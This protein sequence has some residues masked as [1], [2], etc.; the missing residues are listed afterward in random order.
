MKNLSL[1]V[2]TLALLILGSCKSDNSG[3]EDLLK[4]VPSSA[5]AVVGIDLQEIIKDAGCSLK[6]NEIVPGKDMEQL[7]AKMSSTGKK[8]LMLLFNGNTG[9]A[10]EAAVIFYD[11][12]RLFLTFNL[13]DSAKFKSFSESQSGEKFYE[14]NGIQLLN[15]KIALKGDQVWVCL[16]DNRRIDPDGIANYASLSESRSFLSTD[17]AKIILEKEDDIVGWGDFSALVSNLSNRS[18]STMVSLAAGL[19]FEDVEAVSFSW[20]F[21]KG[22]ADFELKFLNSKGK[23]AKYLLPADKININTVKKLGGSCDVLAALTLSPKTFEKFEKLGSAFGGQLFGNMKDAFKNIDGTIAVAMSENPDDIN[24]IITTTGPVS[25]D[26][27]SLLTQQGRNISEDGKFILFSKGTPSGALS[28]DAQASLLKDYCM[29]AV[30]QPQ[31]ITRSAEVNSQVASNFSWLTIGF[32]PDDG[33]I[34]LKVELKAV[35]TNQNIL[36]T[37]LKSL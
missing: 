1:W 30:L 9:I 29:G 3:I 34:E 14:E 8:D 21:N 16:S 20:D 5:A 7:I 24:G 37:F 6:N 27:K 22:E 4:T 11:A 19:L 12:G 10:P 31:M 13:Y 26:V 15:N 32:Q 35:D 2:M 25:S 17:M 18:S 33:G 36:I 23:P 28:V